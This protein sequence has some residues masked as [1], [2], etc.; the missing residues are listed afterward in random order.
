MNGA[1]YFRLEKGLSLRQVKRDLGLCYQT[2][3]KVEAVQGS[4]NVSGIYPEVYLKLREYYHVPIDDLLRDDYPERISNKGKPVG[5]ATECRTNPITNFRRK[6]GLALRT[7]GQ[8]LGVSYET[9]RKICMQEDAPVEYIRILADYCGLSED[10]FR[11][12]YGGGENAC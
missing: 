4:E 6:N 5:S 3:N 10:A 7:M 9:V 1:K 11:A 2:L 8:I 12:E